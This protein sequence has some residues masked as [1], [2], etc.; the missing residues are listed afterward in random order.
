MWIWI[1][2]VYFFGSLKN[3][4]NF[5]GDRSKIS[6]TSAKASASNPPAQKPA[7][8]RPPHAKSAAAVQAQV[9][10]I[11]VGFIFLVGS[12]NSWMSSSYGYY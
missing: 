7:A 11:Y 6:Q 3:L 10:R 1:L 2:H 8:Y 5:S 4:D 12:S 9:Y